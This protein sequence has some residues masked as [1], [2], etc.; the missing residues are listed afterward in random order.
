MRPTSTSSGR[1][2][3]SNAWT[4]RAR[5]AG[6]ETLAAWLLNPATVEEILQRQAAVAELR[7][8]LDL[9]E[10]LEL[11]GADVRVGIDPESLSAWGQEPRVFAP[12]AVTIAV[13]A[14]VLAIL[15]VITLL[16][17]AVLGVTGPS[18]FFAVA[19]AEILFTMKTWSRVHHVIATLDRR[20][21]D[22]VLLSALLK[23]LE[24]ETFEATAL[25][26]LRASLETDGVPASR[27]IA[28][29]ARLL[30]LLNSQKNQ[31]FAPIAAILLWSLQITLAID[32]WRA[33]QGPR[34]RAGSPRWASSRRFAPSLRTRGSA[35]GIS[36]PRSSPKGPRSRRS[37]SATR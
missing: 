23:R 27:R 30:H 19:I 10:E 6:E 22:L 28:K 13:T 5:G 17:W 4:R 31:F 36:S 16:V 29:L 9:R 7:P 3:S 11:L 34:S 14:A 33:A 24:H 15:A 18:P 32:A 8:R 37:G 20:T 2:R 35:R 12:G 25:R 26:R 1:A 21:H